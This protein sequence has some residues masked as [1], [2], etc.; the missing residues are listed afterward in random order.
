MGDMGEVE[1]LYRGSGSL[2]SP[3]WTKGPCGWDAFSG[4]HFPGDTP[5][6]FNSFMFLPK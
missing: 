2:A 4:S 1:R 5:L 3:V 6:E